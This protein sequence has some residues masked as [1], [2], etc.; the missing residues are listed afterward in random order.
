MTT[1]LDEASVI[2]AALSVL[3]EDMWD[4]NDDACDCTF[5]RIGFWTNPYLGETLE[6]RMCCIWTELY[7]LFPDKVR[8]TPAFFDYNANEWAPEPMAW[9][10]ET[11]MPPSIWYRQL[12]RQQGRSVA[13]IREEY[14]HRDDERPRGVARPVEPTAEPEPDMLGMLLQIVMDM[15]NRMDALEAK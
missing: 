2:A 5:Q 10:G 12:A 6:V 13:E 11:D 7:K 4:V 9:N 8:V 1:A 15:A 14:R 3:P